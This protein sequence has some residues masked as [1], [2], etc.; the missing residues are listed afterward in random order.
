MHHKS[1][2]TAAQFDIDFDEFGDSF[3]HDV[4]ERQLKATMAIMPSVDVST[5]Y[6]FALLVGCICIDGSQ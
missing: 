2:S 6:F 5:V 1:P 4:D 3:T